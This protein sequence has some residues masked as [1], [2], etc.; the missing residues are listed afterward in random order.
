[1]FWT[2]LFRGLLFTI[3]YSAV[4]V[5]IVKVAVAANLEWFVP[6]ATYRSLSHRNQIFTA[7][8]VC[9]SIHA[10]ATGSL[11]GYLVLSGAFRNANIFTTYPPLLDW[12]YPHLAGYTLYD[13]GTMY[14]QQASHWTMWLHHYM[15]FYCCLLMPHYRACAIISTY[16]MVSELTAIFQNC[17]W[18]YQFVWNPAVAPLADETS[19]AASLDSSRISTEAESSGQYHLR[20]S[21][22]S[23]SAEAPLINSGS[24]LSQATAG[25]AEST[26]KTSTYSLLLL[27]RALSF[28]LFRAWIFPY[29]FFL[30]PQ[31]GNGF[32]AIVSELMTQPLAVSVPGFLMFWLLGLL[33][34]AWTIM[35][36]KVWL[37]HR[38]VP[39]SSG[40][41]EPAARSKSGASQ[42][43]VRAK[44]QES[45]T[46]QK[47][48]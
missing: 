15:T 42:P 14:L 45:A 27:L 22:S 3:A 38:Q 4:H 35:T 8:K 6:L 48:E 31:L 26:A 24:H 12:I 25:Q 2:C 5:G 7:E 43:L 44:P 28:L 41:G 18:F 47:E 46:F 23:Q 29:L 20:I 30:L 1:M 13:M 33:N 32:Y 36:F 40:C 10:L 34:T 17:L 37:R 9:S 16:Y 11:A 39:D 21:M 19:S